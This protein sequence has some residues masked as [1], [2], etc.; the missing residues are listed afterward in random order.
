MTQ[1]INDDSTKVTREG[2]VLKY[3]FLLINMWPPSTPWT[4]MRSKNN[5]PCNYGLNVTKVSCNYP[6]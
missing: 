3:Y 6:F 2:N 5:L 4:D 1:S